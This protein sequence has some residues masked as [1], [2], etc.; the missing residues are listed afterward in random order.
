VCSSVWLGRLQGYA[1]CPFRVPVVGEGCCWPCSRL[2][3]TCVL[4]VSDCA[5]AIK[6]GLL[7][8]RTDTTALNAVSS[9]CLVCVSVCAE[10]LDWCLWR[11]TV[12]YT[13]CAVLCCAE[14]QSCYRG[15]N[16]TLFVPERSHRLSKKEASSI[17]FDNGHMQMTTQCSAWLVKL[18][19]LSC[20]SAPK[21]SLHV[22]NLHE[23][24]MRLV[25]VPA[26]R[27]S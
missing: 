22:E 16:P 4:G 27:T 9:P 25:R 18:T 14:Q 24:F 2:P 20:T 17:R 13:T 26:R 21:I 11:C 3:D 5:D 15:I 6:H 1:V 12:V 10:L 19:H 7:C 8:C 23:S